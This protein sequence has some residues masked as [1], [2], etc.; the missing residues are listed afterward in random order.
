MED[1]VQPANLRGR[2][3]IWA[4]EETR[5]GAL[6]RKSGALLEAI[7]YRG[8]LPRGDVERVLGAS[9]RTARRLTASLIERGV[10]TS[11]SPSAL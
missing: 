4:E 11:D 5:L 3:L 10:V 7:L 2:I 6:P 9:D 8:A 1:L